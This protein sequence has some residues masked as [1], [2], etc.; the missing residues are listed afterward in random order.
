MTTATEVWLQTVG[1]DTEADRLM[2]REAVREDC[3]RDAQGGAQTD[4]SHWFVR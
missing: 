4:G 1:G 2:E 3:Q